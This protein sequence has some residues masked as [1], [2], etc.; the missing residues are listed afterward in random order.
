MLAR[1]GPVL[2]G[3]HEAKLHRAIREPEIIRRTRSRRLVWLCRSHCRRWLRLDTIDRRPAGRG[4]ATGGSFRYCRFVWRIVDCALRA[5]WREPGL[6]MG[7]LSARNANSVFGFSCIIRQ[8]WRTS[9]LPWRF[10]R[11][12]PAERA[13]GRTLSTVRAA[14]SRQLGFARNRPWGIALGESARGGLQE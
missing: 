2:I 11:Q 13:H 6:S 1:R 4:T 8:S 10:M 9:R 3:L 14:P 12:Y 7:L 5:T